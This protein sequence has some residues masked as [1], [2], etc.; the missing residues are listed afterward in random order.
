[1][2]YTGFLLDGPAAVR[3]PRGTGPGVEVRSEMAALALGKAEVRRR[4]R[5]VA[6]LAF[7]SPVAAAHVAAERL[8][9]TLVNMRFVKP[10]DRAMVLDVAA[11]HELL[12]TVEE[13]ALWGGAGSAV[14]D[15]LSRFELLCPILTLGLPDRF[16]EHG[17]RQALLAQAGL[18]ADGIVAAIEER[19]RDTTCQARPMPVK[20]E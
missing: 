20:F 10:L 5:R 6:I 8:D 9:A 15:A 2:L 19:L 12:V 13:N 11:S 7:G 1:M 3:Y 4:G 14:A 18:D 17:D 16:V